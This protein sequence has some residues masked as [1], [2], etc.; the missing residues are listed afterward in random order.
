MQRLPGFLGRHLSSWH[1]SHSLQCLL[2]QMGLRQ[3]GMP[4]ACT[5]EQARL[6]VDA[7]ALLAYPLPLL[8]NIRRLPAI[9]R[10]S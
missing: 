9:L 4:Q 6:D 2:C 1:L 7:L 8:Q 3:T 10:P 5:A